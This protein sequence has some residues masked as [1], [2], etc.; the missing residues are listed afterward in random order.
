MNSSG[1]QID[2]YVPVLAEVVEPAERGQM[3]VET[4]P[5]IEQRRAVLWPLLLFVATCWSTYHAGAISSPNYAY[6]GILYA[7]AVMFILSAHELGHFFQTLRYRIPA[8]LP[9]FIPMPISPLGTMGAVIGMAP[10][11]G[12]R[13]ALF[14]VA[15][16]GPLAGL[17]PSLLCCVWGLYLSQAVPLEVALRQVGEGSPIIGVPIIF[18][19]LQEWI[20]GPLPPGMAIDLHPIAFAGWVGLL[21]TA[22]NLFPIGQLDGGHTLYAL[23]GKKAHTVAR[24]TWAGCLAAVVVSGAWG[25][26]L[27]LGL[28]WMMG[29]D[30]PPTAN[31]Q[32]PLGGARKLIGWALLMFVPLGFTP[33]PFLFAQPRQAP[34]RIEVPRVV[35]QPRV[36]PGAWPRL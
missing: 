17:I 20:L 8:S 12:D 30:H 33:T 9:M 1:H 6:G 23:L 36:I 28:L 22:L 34:Q 13:K 4:E 3:A 16:S 26:S 7:A 27:M 21:I 10:G 32:A 24:L 19:W 15:V 31:D 35:E 14:D 25:W 5:A 11:E 29:T 2:V 18:R